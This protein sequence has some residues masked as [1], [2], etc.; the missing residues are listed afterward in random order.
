MDAFRGI[1]FAL[2]P[3]GDLRLRTPQPFNKTLSGIQ[4][5]TVG[6]LDCPQQVTGN[7]A[8][9]AAIVAALGEA[10]K[11]LL[12]VNQISEDCLYLNVFRPAGVAQGANLPVLFWIVRSDSKYVFCVPQAD[13][14]SV[15]RRV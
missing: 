5:A 2:P 7:Y 3:V 10:Q 12:P 14:T 6:K 8:L 1:P 11:F 13:F 4:D 15:W 9:P